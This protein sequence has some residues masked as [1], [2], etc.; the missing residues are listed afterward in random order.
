MASKFQYEYICVCGDPDVCEGPD[1]YAHIKT[2]WGNEYD[3]RINNVIYWIFDAEE[4]QTPRFNLDNIILL[5]IDKYCEHYNE[6]PDTTAIKFIVWGVYHTWSST[7]PV[8]LTVLNHCK[9]LV[10]S[11]GTKLYPGRPF[12]WSPVRSPRGLRYER[13][14]LSIY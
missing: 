5:A 7:P 13:P 11:P 12:C 14:V 3:S 10:H 8:Y 9:K 6:Y 1:C 4:V 2:H